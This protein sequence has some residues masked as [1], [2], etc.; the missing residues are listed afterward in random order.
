MSGPGLHA[1]R[2]DWDSV[3]CYNH[4]SWAGSWQGNCRVSPRLGNNDFWCVGPAV[5]TRWPSVPESFVH[6]TGWLSPDLSGGVHQ[7]SLFAIT[8]DSGPRALG[9]ESAWSWCTVNSRVSR[10]VLGERLTLWLWFLS[11]ASCFL[12]FT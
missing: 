2:T 5:A 8:V 9:W 7:S 6:C 4:R 12:Y 10:P 11:W 1:T 3:Y